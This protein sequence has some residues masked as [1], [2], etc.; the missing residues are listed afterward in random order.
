M[1]SKILLLGEKAITNLTHICGSVQPAKE[2]L[3]FVV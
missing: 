1:A 3:D 2:Y